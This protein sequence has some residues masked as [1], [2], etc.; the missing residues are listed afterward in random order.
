MAFEELGEWGSDELV[1][2]LQ[3]CENTI[4]KGIADGNSTEKIIAI[5]AHLKSRGEWY[6]HHDESLEL[7]E[8]C[9]KCG[10]Y[11]LYEEQ[12]DNE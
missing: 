3:L 5:K 9:T 8:H 4:L 10:R 1:H 7:L 6:C 12:P 11:Y 2:L